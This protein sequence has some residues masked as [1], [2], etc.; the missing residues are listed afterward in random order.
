MSFMVSL[1]AIWNGWAT[2]F[3]FLIAWVTISN[4]ATMYDFA[5]LYAEG[6]WWLSGI[7]PGAHVLSYPYAYPPSSLPFFG[8]F[9]QFSY[10]FAAQ[11]WT[12]MSLGVFIVA[13]LS[14]AVTLKVNR[15][16]LFVSIAALLFFTSYALRAELQLGQINLFL[17]GLTVLSLVAHR[18]EHSRVS[19]TLLAIGTLLKGSPV[20]FLLYFVVFYRDFRYLIHFLESTVAI[21]GL[22]L[23]VVPIQLYWIWMTNVFPTLF[24]SANLSINESLTG[25]ISLSGL[26]YLTPIVFAAGIC[27]FVAFAYRL[28]PNA[29]SKL[30]APQTLTADAMFLMNSLVL[31][32]LGTRC[33]PQDY[34]WTILPTAL[35]LSTLLVENVK[36]SYAVAVGVA[37]LLFN[38]DTYPPFMY[39]LGQYATLAA[40]VPR[41]QAIPTGLLG[42]LLMA[43]CL[44]LL[45]IRPRV[46]LLPNRLT[47]K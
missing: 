17:E 8:L 22:S 7:S 30:S 23:L 11:L 14:T 42:G 24:V 10:G 2:F 28:S 6:K 29:L 20:L 44:I 40:Y 26:G 27:L 46:I 45:L 5:N 21:L 13:L 1:W 43:P 31:L 39:Y 4:P 41:A 16:Y 3:L 18:S 38:F 25:P 9:A 12:A 32:L 36:T 35:F 47:R 15:R 34:V 19:A 33:W 37:A